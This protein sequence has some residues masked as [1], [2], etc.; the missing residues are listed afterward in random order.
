MAGVFTG[1]RRAM[2]FADITDEPK[3]GA[4]QSN[5]YIEAF[6]LPIMRF[7]QH[8]VLTTIC[9]M[10]RWCRCYPGTD[11]LTSSGRYP[12]VRRRAFRGQLAHGVARRA[13]VN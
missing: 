1:S 6:T 13:R 5:Y 4:P 9:A 3:R 8:R 11:P 7:R 2:L 12:N 10:P